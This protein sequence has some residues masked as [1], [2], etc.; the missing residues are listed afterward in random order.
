MRLEPSSEAGREG[1]RVRRPDSHPDRTGSG[2]PRS[3]P[4]AAS[5]RVELGEG[6]QHG[7]RLGMQARGPGGFEAG[8]EQFLDPPEI[9]YAGGV[10]VCEGPPPRSAGRR[11]NRA[12]ACRGRPVR[13]PQRPAGSRRSGAGTRRPRRRA[14]HRRP[15]ACRHCSAALETAACSNCIVCIVSSEPPDSVGTT[16]PSCVPRRIRVRSLHSGRSGSSEALKWE[17]AGRRAN[18]KPPADCAATG[19]MSRGLSRRSIRAMVKK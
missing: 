6:H 17:A 9:A 13:R 15:H 10:S 11:P 18:R 8:V 4:A 7:R 1:G 12:A 14:E 16:L 5:I 3:C 2:R 19:R